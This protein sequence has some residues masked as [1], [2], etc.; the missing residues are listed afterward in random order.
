ME[1]RQQTR[2][3]CVVMAAG[4]SSR[5]GGDKLMERLDGKSLIRRALEAIPEGVFSG[6]AV[7]TRLTEAE[8]IA[9]QH[10]W[11]IVRNDVPEAGVSRTIRMGTE[12]LLGCDAIL[13]LVAD[14]PLLSAETV[15]RVV[16]RWKE[17]P[18]CIV[19]AAHHGKRGNPCIFPRDL[20]PELMALEG[21]CG[22]TAVIR[23]HPERL[24]LVE[25]DAWELEDVDTPETLCAL[26]DIR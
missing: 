24:L 11:V 23:A 9:R 13:Y 5:F 7:V 3:G 2:I 25:T 4:S 18:E 8:D 6:V 20:Y 12:A 19:G 10:G 17:R 15:E 21:D 22:G 14:Q 26:R 1:R 16:A